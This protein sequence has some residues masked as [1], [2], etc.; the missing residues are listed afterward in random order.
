MDESLIRTTF[1]FLHS[2]AEKKAE[3]LMGNQGGKSRGF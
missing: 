2:Y 3:E 1:T